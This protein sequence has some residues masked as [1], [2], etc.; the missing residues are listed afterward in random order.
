MAKNQVTTEVSNESK[1]DP[2]PLEKGI[3]IVRLP[4][5]EDIKI[6]DLA[7]DTPAAEILELLCGVSDNPALT[8][9]RIDGDEI[10]EETFNRVITLITDA[11]EKGEYQQASQH[12]I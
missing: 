8:L 11:E 12:I 1:I 6:G 7:M 4:H 3:I 5:G 9:A 10:D 2:A